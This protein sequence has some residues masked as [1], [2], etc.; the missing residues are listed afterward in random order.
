MRQP[1]WSQVLSLSGMHLHLYGK[2]EAKVGRKMGHLTVTG[3]D[4]QETRQRA[5]Q[6]ASILGIDTW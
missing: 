5:H 4:I 6:A 1:N 2:N 3:V